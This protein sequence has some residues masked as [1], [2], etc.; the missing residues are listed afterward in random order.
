MISSKK[1]KAAKKKVLFFTIQ[2]LNKM[3]LEQLVYNVTV[4]KT[5][6]IANHFQRLRTDLIL[7]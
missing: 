3:S 1:E 5:Y 4:F 6:S 7:N 2:F